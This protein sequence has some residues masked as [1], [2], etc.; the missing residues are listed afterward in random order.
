MIVS[1]LGTF[2]GMMALDISI[3]TL[4]LFG[5]VLAIG[6]VVD[7]AIVVIENVE[8]NM[9]ALGISAKEAAHRAMQEVT[10]L[11]SLSCWYCARCLFCC[12][13]WGHRRAAL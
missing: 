11:S 5:M 3:N 12:L 13:P 7:D 4:T 1:I 2:A 6:I 10:G 9:R 8:H